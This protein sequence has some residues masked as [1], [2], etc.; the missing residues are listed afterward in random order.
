MRPKETN[1]II[2]FLESG[3]GSVDNIVNYFMLITDSFFSKALRGNNPDEERTDDEKA[4]ISD[5]FMLSFLQNDVM[6]SLITF[7]D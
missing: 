3:A 5:W 4:H 2:R 6:F 7:L 1:Q